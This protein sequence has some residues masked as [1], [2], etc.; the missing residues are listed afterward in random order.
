MKISQLFLAL[1]G[2]FALIELSSHLLENQ[3]LHFYMKPLLMP[4]LAAYFATKSAKVFK[5]GILVLTALFFSFLGDTFLLFDA[6]APIY[7]IL[8]LSM[9]LLAHVFYIVFFS[10][11]ASERKIFKNPVLLLLVAAYGI[12][13]VAYLLPHLGEML[14]PVVVYALVIMT[15]LIFALNLVLNSAKG[16]IFICVGA[17]LFVI[18]D[19]LIAI[20]K[21]ALKL[22]Q[23]QFLIMITYIAAQWAII[24]GAIRNSEQ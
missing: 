7:F 5:S 19:S 1:F 2:L 13:L 3:Q 6:K 12:G 21:F 22:W 10:K 8:G 15:M 11:K 17:L 23:A 14:V 20:D 24:E 4:L 18:S 9:F 16:A